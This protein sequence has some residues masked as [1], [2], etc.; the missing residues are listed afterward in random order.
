MFWSFADGAEVVGRFTRLSHL[1]RTPSA[2]T[3]T[4]GDPRAA[5]PRQK[6]SKA[7]L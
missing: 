2:H 6:T 7:Q 1:P 4:T 3:L 5:L